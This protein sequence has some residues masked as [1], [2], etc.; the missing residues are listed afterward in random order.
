MDALYKSDFFPVLR[1]AKSRRMFPLVIPVVVVAVFGVRFVLSE[2]L[3]P[4]MVPTHHSMVQNIRQ[5]LFFSFAVHIFTQF[6]HTYVDDREREEK[7]DRK[8]RRDKKTATTTQV[9]IFIHFMPSLVLSLFSYF[10]SY[11]LLFSLSITISSLL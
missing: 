6:V 7:R 8:E 2:V 5:V 1:R 3:F 4:E 9:W 10:S 11:L